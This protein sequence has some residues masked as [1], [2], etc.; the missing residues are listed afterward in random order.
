MGMLTLFRRHYPPCKHAGHKQP[1]RYRT[2][3]CPIWVQ[4]SL[5]GEYIK[6]ALELRSLEARFRPRA[7]LGGIR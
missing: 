5:R 7:R 2:C 1:R 6:E 4:G 3:Q